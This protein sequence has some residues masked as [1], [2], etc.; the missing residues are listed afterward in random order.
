MI[1][2]MVPLFVKLEVCPRLSIEIAV[3]RASVRARGFS[4][5][6]NTTSAAS[7]DVASIM[8]ELLICSAM[9]LGPNTMTRAMPVC[10]GVAGSAPSIILRGATNVVAVIDPVLLMPPSSV[11]SIAEKAVASV[12][13]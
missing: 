2:L 4:G 11:V 7:E 6:A 1:A 8:P 3:A 5:S 12:R 10:S 13:S 9:A